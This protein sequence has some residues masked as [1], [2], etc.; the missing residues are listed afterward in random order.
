VDLDLGGKEAVDV[1]RRHA[2]VAGNVGNGRLRITV[3]AKQPLGGVE[4]AGHILLSRGFKGVFG[5]VV[6]EFYHLNYD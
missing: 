2:E 1:G 5:D 6:H 4:N 3:V